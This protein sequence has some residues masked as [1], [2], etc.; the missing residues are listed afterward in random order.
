MTILATF[1]EWPE[2][3]WRGLPQPPRIAPVGPAPAK[4]PFVAGAVAGGRILRTLDDLDSAPDQDLSPALR[5]LRDD[6]RGLSRQRGRPYPHALRQFRVLGVWGQSPRRIPPPAYDPWLPSIQAFLAGKRIVTT[7]EVSLHG[8][9]PAGRRH[10][11]RRIAALLRLLGWRRW[12]TDW[13][14]YWVPS[15]S[16]TPKRCSLLRPTS[17]MD[18][19][20]RQVTARKRYRP[21]AGRRPISR[22]SPSE[23]PSWPLGRW[24]RS[25]HG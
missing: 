7:L 15:D 6:P 24:M 22:T 9:P 25:R 23:R 2:E 13:G 12:R 20:P 17:Y 4:R 19:R 1:T 16:A 3:L 10:A 18:G 5:N 8:C 14:G 11:F 21:R